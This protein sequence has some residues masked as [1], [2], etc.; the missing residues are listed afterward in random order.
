ML[1]QLVL[2]WATIA[3]RAA[4][5]GGAE[6]SMLGRD[7]APGRRRNQNSFP[8]PAGMAELWTSSL[9]NPLAGAVGQGRHPGAARGLAGARALSLGKDAETD[10]QPYTGPGRD[11][12]P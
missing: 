1:S 2:R 7:P 10:H 4:W 5:R 9:A 8:D 11:P 12:G 6:C 3:G